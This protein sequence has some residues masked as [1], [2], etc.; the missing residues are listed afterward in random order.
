MARPQLEDGH[1][2]IAH[3]IVEALCRINLT[4]YESR[5]LWALFRKTYGWHKKWDRISYTKW[6]EVT[7]LDRWH[8]ARTLKQLIARKIIAQR[9]NG[10]K[11]EYAFQK[12]YEQWIKEF[13]RHDLLPSGATDKQSLPRGEKSLPPGAKPLPSGATKSLPPGVNTKEK[14]DTRQKKRQK[15]E[16]F[17]LPEW[18]D[19]STW[20]AFL[21]MRRKKKAVSTEYALS[22][23]VKD[24]EKFKALGD[25]PNEVLKRSITNSWKGVFPLKGGQDG[26]YRRGDKEYTAEEL[27]KSLE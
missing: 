25:D 1:T 18:I 19:K 26:T 7:G 2:D 5:I 3:E 12:D 27:R 24:L 13:H 17:I 16:K 6:E 21:E 23:I 20:G 9:G 14:K 15:I 4:A 10:Y 22:C 11:I 8:I